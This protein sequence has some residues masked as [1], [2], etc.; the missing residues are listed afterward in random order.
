MPT[1]LVLLFNWG[2]QNCSHILVNLSFIDPSRENCSCRLSPNRILPI[3]SMESQ[4]LE[5]LLHS[6]NRICQTKL[7]HST[8]PFSSHWR[9]L[10]PIPRAQ[11]MLIWRER[12]FCRASAARV[13]QTPHWNSNRNGAWM[14][15]AHIFISADGSWGYAAMGVGRSMRGIT[16]RYISSWGIFKI[17]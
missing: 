3:S 16:M 2:L 14:A 12:A 5:S 7:S 9:L 6:H 13:S 8:S 1:L 15:R 11:I 17:R 4:K 10:P